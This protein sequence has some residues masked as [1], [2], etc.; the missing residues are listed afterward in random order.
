MHNF[1]LSEEHQ[2]VLETVRKFVKDVAEP[3]ALACDEHGEFVRAQIDQ[4]AEL[5][6]LGLP[7]G[8]ASGGAGMGWV[9]TV[10]A[11]EEIATA[12]SSTAQVLA[13][14]AAI[15]APA[16]EGLE[17][18]KA[19]LGELC[20]GEKLA[21]WVGPDARLTLDAAGK[22]TGVAPLV[23]G[24]GEAQVFV[25]ACRQGD[26]PALAVVEATAAKITAARPLGFRATAPAQV[27]FAG[28]AA[29]VVAVGPDA[30]AA[31]VR[32][33][34]GACASAAAIASGLLAS[35]LRLSVA[36]ARERIAFGKPLTA[37][38]AVA[39]K[40]ARM[41]RRL[42]AARHGA[43]HVARLL[44]AGEGTREAAWVAKLEAVDAAVEGADEAIQ[45]HGGYGFVVEY[46]VER[47]YRDAKTLEVLEGGHERLRDDLAALAVGGA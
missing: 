3:K 33:E 44:D 16:L 47:H 9:A 19:L 4:L 43:Y 1:Q 42:A 20:M 30:Q 15:A 35:S 34:I 28:A 36:Y 32:A 22:L 31:W 10:V 21:A 23:T 6:M 8:E 45:I 18:G 24:G 37:Q 38:Q 2:M 11:L 40:L 39:H 14:H 13:G 26:Q 7:V 41:Q 25:V 5:G 27:E 46:H 17:A 12:C 29:T